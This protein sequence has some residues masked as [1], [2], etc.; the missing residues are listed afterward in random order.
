MRRPQATLDSPCNY[1]V[2]GEH[3]NDPT[4]LLALGDDGRFYSLNLLDGQTE[5]TELTDE[6]LMDACDPSE[7]LSRIHLN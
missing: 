5:P 3:L 4:H 7:K 6:W 2:I 1:E